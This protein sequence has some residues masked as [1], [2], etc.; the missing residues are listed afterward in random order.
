[1]RHPV[2]ICSDQQ[3]IQSEVRRLKRNHI[4]GISGMKNFVNLSNEENINGLF[5]V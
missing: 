1:M 3:R 5:S 4:T 2:K